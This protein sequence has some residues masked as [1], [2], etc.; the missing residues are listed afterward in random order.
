MSAVPGNYVDA[1]RCGDAPLTCLLGKLLRDAGRAPDHL[2]INALLGRSVQLSADA[3][4]DCLRGW[5]DYGHDV[6]LPTAGRALGL[7]IRD[8]H[9]AA[10]ARGLRQAAGFQQH[11][12]ASYRPLIERALEHN[13]PVIAWLGPEGQGPSNLVD[14]RSGEG[15]GPAKDP[16]ACRG[17]ETGS[18]GKVAKS[19][20]GLITAVVEEGVGFRMAVVPMVGTN[21]G[22]SSS[23]QD[24]HGV[25]SG[26][27]D[28]GGAAFVEI[29]PNVPPVQCYVVEEI[30][31]PG[32]DDAAR[33]SL[34]LTHAR[35][36]LTGRLPEHLGLISGPAAFAR[37]ATLIER[38]AR[39]DGLPSAACGH[40]RLVRFVRAGFAS[41]RLFVRAWRD[42]E[43]VLPAALADVFDSCAM[44]VIEHVLGTL[45]F[46]TQGD[47]Q[48]DAPTVAGSQTASPDRASPASAGPDAAASPDAATAAGSA[49]SAQPARAAAVDSAT[50]ANLAIPGNAPLTDVALEAALA[51]PQRRTHI[52]NH[53]RHAR[54]AA[55]RLGTAL[56]AAGV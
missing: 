21:I 5:A 38:P 49:G 19:A 50:A 44:Q 53:L 36:L 3:D 27:T 7:R 13:Q 35:I 55:L 56:Q 34:A 39:A 12:D 14:A 51:D 16:S 41:A 18:A 46:D 2:L 43:D 23:G 47:G 6:F 42:R 17:K 15:D 33:A 29:V 10:A 11:F 26:G 24:S 28:P 9:P 52:A 20:W 32:I 8:L 1:A 40:L 48:R 45:S 4:D 30:G 25:A 31:A 22:G 54:A 37:W